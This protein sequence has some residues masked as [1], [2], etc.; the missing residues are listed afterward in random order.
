ME[1]VCG[2][3][4][5]GWSV[6]SCVGVPGCVGDVG[7]CAEG[8]GGVGMLRG[9]WSRGVWRN[10]VCRCMLGWHVWCFAAV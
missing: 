8:V 3:H 5:W 2:D 6:E 7:M 1:F 9:V 4:M 10:V